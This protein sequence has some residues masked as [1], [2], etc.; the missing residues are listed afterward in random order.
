MTIKGL[1]DRAGE[2]LRGAGPHSEIV[3]SSRI[4]L[5]RNLAGY[6]FV[7]QAT[8]RVQQEIL[9]R[10]KQ[11]ITNTEMGDEVLWVD[12]R[13]CPEVDRQ[14]LVERHLISRQHA[15]GEKIVRAVAVGSQEMFSIMVNE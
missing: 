13:Q 8:T 15:M 12:L 5:A 9:D 10:C 1:T 11:V 3:I 4:R 2:W 14:L 6:P 7:N